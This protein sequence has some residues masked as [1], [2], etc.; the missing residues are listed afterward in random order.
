[1]LCWRHVAD[2]CERLPPAGR[3]NSP[4]PDVTSSPAKRPVIGLRTESPS[5]AN[6]LAG[7]DSL[8]LCPIKLEAR[9]GFEPAIGGCLNGEICAMLQ[10]LPAGVSI[11]VVGGARKIRATAHL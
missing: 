5:W 9:A 6:Q 3:K 11:S 4:F 1:M 8:G 2:R 10:T 7:I